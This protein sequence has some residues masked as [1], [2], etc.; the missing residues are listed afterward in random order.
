MSL[1]SLL[2]NKDLWRAQKLF[3][4]LWTQNLIPSHALT[5]FHLYNLEILSVP[6]RKALCRR[7]ANRE[8]AM[9]RNQGKYISALHS[10]KAACLGQP[11]GCQ[12]ADLLLHVFLPGSSTS[13]LT[14]PQAGV[15]CWP[16]HPLSGGCCGA[17][18]SL[19]VVPQYNH[20]LLYRNRW[21]LTCREQK[22]KQFSSNQEIICCLFSTSSATLKAVLKHFRAKYYKTSILPYMV[23]G[24]DFAAFFSFYEILKNK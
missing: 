15:S 21:N 11:R 17:T 22:R 14:Q 20:V 2:R 10:R 3:I 5:A 7:F 13:Y 1:L 6:F 12:K 24:Q 9:W 19:S 23:S 8:E 18:C 16:L 4:C